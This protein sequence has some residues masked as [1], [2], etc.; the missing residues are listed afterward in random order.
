MKGEEKVVVES[1]VLGTCRVPTNYCLVPSELGV[2]HYRGHMVGHD[3]VSHVY[4]PFK[5]SMLLLCLPHKI[6]IVF[7]QR[8]RKCD[9]EDY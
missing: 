7:E 9:C 4:N 1:T 3:E 8:T 5:V 2:G 6:D